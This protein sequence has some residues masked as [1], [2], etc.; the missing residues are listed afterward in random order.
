MTWDSLAYLLGVYW[1]FLSV[2]AVIGLVTGWL[3][4]S[5]PKP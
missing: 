1:P 5:S 4:F 3:S 2:A